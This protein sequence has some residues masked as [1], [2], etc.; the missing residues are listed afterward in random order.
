VGLRGLADWYANLTLRLFKAEHVMEADGW[1]EV[2]GRAGFAVEHHEPYMPLRA[3]E[4]QDI[5]LPTAVPSKIAK[6]LFGRLFFLP[7]LHRACVRLYR[8]TLMR[9]YEERT[10]LGSG[11]LLVARRLAAPTS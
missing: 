3:T 7:R 2:L 8:G 5:F 6:R 11:T 4:L 9:P 10:P 1:A